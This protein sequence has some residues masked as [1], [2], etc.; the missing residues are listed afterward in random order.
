MNAPISRVLPTPVASAKQSD[1]NSRSKSVTDGNSLRIA[2]SAAAT[3]APF[4]RRHDLGDAVE[5]LQRVALRRAQAQAA[6]DGV[7]VA[8]VTSHP[9]WRRFGRRSANTREAARPSVRDLRLH[10]APTTARSSAKYRCATTS[11]NVPRLAQ[12]TSGIPAFASSGEPLGGFSDDFKIATTV[13]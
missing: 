11:R 12:S 7:D 8:A 4:L 5:D 2:A 10:D 9:R 3:S 6:G 1:G 13:A